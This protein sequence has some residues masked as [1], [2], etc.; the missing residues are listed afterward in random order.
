MES[1][2]IFDKIDEVSNDFGNLREVYARNTKVNFDKPVNVK[3]PIP[4]IPIISKPK[5]KIKGGGKLFSPIIKAI[6][7]PILKI[8]DVF[9]KPLNFIIKTI[10]L[11]TDIINK[12]IYYVKCGFFLLINFFTV[13]CVFWYVLNLV[14]TVIYLP[15]AF[16]FWLIGINDLIEEYIWGPIYIADE[17]VYDYSGFHFAH[18]PDNIMKACYSCSGKLEVLGVSNFSFIGDMFKEM[19]NLFPKPN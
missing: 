6:A 10:N 5:I 13:P 3:G 8:V 15:F 11:I 1:P 12:A 18:F 16:I 14:C 7:N 4:A 17:V 19:L 9:I 2:D